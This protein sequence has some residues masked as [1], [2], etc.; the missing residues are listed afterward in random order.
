MNTKDITLTPLNLIKEIGV[1]D[2]D[3]CGFKGHKTAKRIYI[4]PKEDGLR[5]RWFGKVWLNPPYSETIKWISKMSK[6]NNGI[7][8][9]LASTETNWFQKYVLN[10][11]NSIFFLKSRPKFLNC[12]Y[13]VVNLMRGI[14]LVSYGKCHNLLKNCKLDG[15]FKTLI[16]TKKE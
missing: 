16:S 3:P 10:K 14:V 4:L 7:A 12:K 8:C 6:H 13:E 11:S 1:F 9:V 5:L 15:V 2:L